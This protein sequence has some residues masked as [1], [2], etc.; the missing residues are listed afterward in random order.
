VTDNRAASL[1]DWTQF[2]IT[3]PA[4]ARLPGGGGYPINGLYDLVPG[5][6]GLVDQLTQHSSNFAEQTENWHGVDVTF[7]ARLRLG[8]TAQGGFS[9][10]RRLADNC[11]LR[12]ALPEL[13]LTGTR[14]T[15]NDAVPP[16]T[17]NF[18]TPTNPYCRVVEPFLTQMRG[19]ATYT[20][21]RVDVQVSGTWQSNPGPE[22][23]AN[24]VVS[25][26][27]A[28]QTLGRDLSGGA[29]IT[30]NLIP[31]GTLYGDRVNSLD[32]RVAK[33]LRFGRTRTQVGVDI[34]NATNTDTPRTFNNSFTPGGNWLVPTSVLTA[35]FVKLGMQFDF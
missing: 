32:F 22:I 33:L 31:S 5:K 29:N 14:S 1:S 4:D 28:K 25:N 20:I 35:R 23:Q 13:G 34:Y 27:L 30:V 24:Y 16:V 11:A 9:T 18:A 17:S 12:A 26:A 6:V 2:G 3:A 21:P 10:G 8:L 19:L 15:E 7:V